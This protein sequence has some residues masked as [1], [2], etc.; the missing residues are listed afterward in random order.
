MQY[1]FNFSFL[2][3]LFFSNIFGQ[4]INY[5]G[6][7]SGTTLE[8]RVYSENVK[9][10]TLKTNHNPY[11]P[12]IIKLN[13]SEKLTLGFDLLYEDN[14]YLNYTIIHCNA[15]WT[16]SELLKSQYIEGF[17]NFLIEDFEFS[18]NT[19]IPYTHYYLTL[20]NF[21]M[22]MMLSGNY[23]LLVYGDD[24]SDPILTKRFVVY[25]EVVNIQ[26]E[27]VRANF[28]DYR[29]THQEIDFVINHPGYEI[30]NPYQD[31]FVSVLQNYNW[32]KSLYNLKP[33]FA[34]N[35]QLDYNYDFENAMSGGNEFRMFDAKD[36]RAKT[37]Q[38]Q[39][40]VLDTT[41]EI[42]LADDYI[43]GIGKYSFLDDINGRFVIRKLD[44]NPN[45]EAD[46][47]WV[48]FYLD[49]P[50]QIEEGDVYVNGA[51]C[52]WRPT[53]ETKMEYDFD[54]KA[55]RKKVLLKQGYYNYQYVVLKP[56]N[57]IDES[58]IEGSY[59]E[60]DNEYLIIVYH[61]EIGLRYDRVVGLSQINFRL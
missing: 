9:T 32:N 7:I 3:L 19:Y 47:I 13:S 60:T 10:V 42:F 14:R 56:N 44:R 36:M 30:P 16:P 43:R 23:V 53:P 51:F 39:K 21:N 1:R 50:K 38:I 48:D 2:F 45:V 15:D 22:K 18:L 20:P 12:A 55:Y 5:A 25:E 52:D 49:S 11:A 57:E 8:D 33:R 6:D 46:Y 27:I 24:E 40:T 59:W 54:R 4:N 28:L 31:L 35:Y 26:T 37:L 61:R 58:I 17:Q 34:S 29:F 41:W